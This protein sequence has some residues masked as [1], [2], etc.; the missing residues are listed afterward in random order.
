[1]VIFI[2]EN[3]FQFFSIIFNYHNNLQNGQI[4]ITNFNEFYE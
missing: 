3:I 4:S 1:M 2:F